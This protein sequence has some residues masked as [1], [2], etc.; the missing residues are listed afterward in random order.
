MT[1]IG[2]NQARLD[3]K[4]T[5]K[6]YADFVKLDMIM[7]LRGI[8]VSGSLPTNGRFGLRARWSSTFLQNQCTN[9]EKYMNS[10]LSQVASLSADSTL[11]TFFEKPQ[12]D[13]RRACLLLSVMKTEARLRLTTFDLARARYRGRMYIWRFAWPSDQDVWLDMQVAQRRFGE[14]DTVKFEHLTVDVDGP[15]VSGRADFGWHLDRELSTTERL[16]WTALRNGALREYIT[17]RCQS[18]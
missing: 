16:V 7:T 12:P 13:D 1:R 6:S 5:V 14:D 11:Q 18:H 8:A 17:P 3:W 10:L 15:L 2:N 4:Y 9:L